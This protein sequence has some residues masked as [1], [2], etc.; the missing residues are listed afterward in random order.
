MRILYVATARMPTEKAHGIQIMK[1]CDAY[2]RL[3]HEVELVVPFRRNDIATD[4]FTYYGVARTFRITTLSVPDLIM[5]GYPGYSLHRFLF[6]M[7]VRR[8]V[9][10]RRFDLI[11]S[12]DEVPLWLLGSVQGI[13]VY[14]AHEGRLNFIVRA[15]VR[16]ARALVVI[17][18]GLCD[19]FTAR[20]VPRGKIVVVPDGVDYEKFALVEDAK[21]ARSILK[22]PL[23][24]GLVLYTGHLYAWKGADTLARA[25]ERLPHITFVFAGG[26]ESD[27][28]HF[29]GRYGKAGNIRILG[30]QPYADMPRY[31]AAADVLVIPNSAKED[32]SRLYTS[33]MKLFEYMAASRPI[34]A[35]DLPS[36]REVLD[37][38]TA[39]FFKPDDARDCARAILETLDDPVAAHMRAARAREQAR[40][41]TWQARAEKI[42]TAVRMS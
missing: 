39:V 4:P 1:M 18:Q 29:R 26:T 27:I 25:A 24:E 9:R 20:S 21:T 16:R 5:F 40:T 17:T 6:G 3:G 23:N 31:L 2:A 38:E 34:V 11:Y 12:R 36:L 7:R 13:R 28:E 22:L 15:V 41:Y 37:E 35:S 33:P 30:K 32:I 8:F 14:E 10:S 42:L 19:F